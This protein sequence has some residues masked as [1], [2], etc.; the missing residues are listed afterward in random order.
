MRGVPSFA[1]SEEL[2]R[3]RAQFD[4]ARADLNAS[5]AEQGFTPKMKSLGTHAQSS[6]RSQSLVQLRIKYMM[7]SRS[8]FKGCV[9]RSYGL[10]PVSA[11]SSA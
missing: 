7:W 8:F 10:F 4:S 1:E 11:K 5:L 9:F 6:P 2:E 3:L